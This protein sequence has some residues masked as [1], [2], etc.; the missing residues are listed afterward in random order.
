MFK[1]KW[2]CY[3]LTFWCLSFPVRGEKITE[4]F[5]LNSDF[6]YRFEIPD[7]AQGSPVNQ[8]YHRGLFRFGGRFK[9]KNQV[10]T[11]FRL[12]TGSGRTS[13][14]HTLGDSDLGNDFAN[15]TLKL[16]RAFVDFGIDEV[17]SIK[18]VIYLGRAPSLAFI[19]K[20]SDLQWDT[21]L[22][23]DG[24]AGKVTFS[25]MPLFISVG[26]YIL[27]QDLARRDSQSYLDQT[28][29]GYGVSYG[30]WD[31][32]LGLGHSAFVGLKGRTPVGQ[33]AAGNSVVDSTYVH[34]YKTVNVGGD[35]SLKSFLG[36]LGLTSEYVFN[37][38]L[39]QQNRAYLVG[40]RWGDTKSLGE[41]FFN[42][43]FRFLEKDS[44]VGALADGDSLVGYGVDGNSHRF[45]VGF[46]PRPG[47]QASIAYFVGKAGISTSGHRR[48]KGQF[49][50]S[51]S[52]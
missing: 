1:I 14:Q 13:T 50:L 8:S 20:A 26:T 2:V 40:L 39:S 15:W 9:L 30:D 3:L 31:W 5:D 28:S 48:N 45:R 18:T 29:L 34:D 12:A 19:P 25:E 4:N 32:N 46:Q 49:D 43:D 35:I 16:D 7:V 24:I 38:A 36:P 37:S 44:L 27:K 51:F 23:L 52:Y 22:N 17:D 11:E 10:Q 47:W 42:Y 41:W 21:D 6:R 33:K